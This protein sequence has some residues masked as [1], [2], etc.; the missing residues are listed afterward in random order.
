MCQASSTVNY[1]SK[2]AAAVPATSLRK[3][4]TPSATFRL[5]MRRDRESNQ[6]SASVHRKISLRRRL[7]SDETQGSIQEVQL[8]SPAA[9]VDE[10]PIVLA[11]PTTTTK[12]AAAAVVLTP[13]TPDLVPT[14]RDKVS[15][16]RWLSPPLLEP[17]LEE[18]EFRSIS[19][20]PDAILIPDF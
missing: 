14:G 11:P 5:S 4:V 8:T 16:L 7:N 12:L 9:V 19:S 20:L 17:S 6:L 1:S 15:S 13:R 18:D 3:P 10:P 2:G